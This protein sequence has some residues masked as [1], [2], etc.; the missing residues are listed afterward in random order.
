MYIN[1]PR[2]N[3]TA[4]MSGT[5]DGLALLE[6]SM[7]RCE[8]LTIVIHDLTDVPRIVHCLRG[9]APRLV[10]CNIT[11]PRRSINHPHEQP[12][13]HQ[14][15]AGEAPRLLRATLPCL[16]LS[17][18]LGSFS[19]LTILRFTDRSRISV[20]QALAPFAFG[21]SMPRLETVVLSKFT[22]DST[23]DSRYWVCNSSI[24]NV[25]LCGENYGDALAVIDRL[26]LPQVISLTISG[27]GLFPINHT[28]GVCSTPL[29]ELISIAFDGDILDYRGLHELIARMPNLTT[30][31]IGSL[32]GLQL[33]AVRGLNQADDDVTGAD[34]STPNEEVIIP[35]P[36]L[37]SLAFRLDTEDTVFDG[38]SVQ[39]G[40]ERFLIDR[41]ATGCA[42]L[43][44]LAIP[45]L[46]EDYPE[47][48]QALL[49]FD[50]KL[51]IEVCS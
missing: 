4:A 41:A 2:G 19:N 43:E 9:R 38:P 48:E 11:F 6:D 46:G 8:S 28:L 36:R 40:L 20:R 39:M 1:F 10:T 17:W 18:P 3:G 32:E 5:R 37:K 14:L 25:V 27:A 34:I 23:E 16:H 51:S 47:L 45:F 13:T 15:F 26:V 35:T 29:S 12:L 24:K 44:N 49:L 22:L 30:A 31:M 42:R 21:E 33:F 50:P 7:D